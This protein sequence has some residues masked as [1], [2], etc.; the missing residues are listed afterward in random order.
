MLNIFIVCRN[1]NIL[2]V[3]SS[4]TMDSIHQ[5]LTNENENSIT[6]QIKWEFLATSVSTNC[7]TV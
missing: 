4:S 1:S 3:R 5:F 6:I 7:F 2:G